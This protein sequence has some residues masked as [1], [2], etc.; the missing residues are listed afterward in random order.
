MQYTSVMLLS[1][2]DFRSTCTLICYDNNENQ[3][4]FLQFQRYTEY[5][6]PEIPVES[7]VA[8][9]TYKTEMLVPNCIG[10]Y[11]RNAVFRPSHFAGTI[12]EKLIPLFDFLGPKQN[13]FSLTV[14]S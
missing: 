10:A 8:R 11:G 9:R 2:T 4:G 12:H 13:F 7:A 3:S 5:A 6:G 1:T 14:C